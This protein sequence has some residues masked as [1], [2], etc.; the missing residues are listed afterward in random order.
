[1]RWKSGVAQSGDAS[2]LTRKIL[3]VLLVII[4]IATLG[5]GLDVCC[6]PAGRGVVTMSDCLLVPLIR[7][8]EC[9]A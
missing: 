7:N 3:V 9:T 2:S 1:M 6:V 8:D 5:L 4:V